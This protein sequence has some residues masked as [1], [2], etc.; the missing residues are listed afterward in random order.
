MY[1]GKDKLRDAVAE[2]TGQSCL[3]E[4]DPAPGQHSTLVALATNLLK[5]PLP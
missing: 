3:L 1:F 2:A 4:S 5:D